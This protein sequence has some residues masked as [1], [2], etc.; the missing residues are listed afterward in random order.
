LSLNESAGKAG[1]IK[2]RVGVSGDGYLGYAVFQRHAR[3]RL[4]LCEPD[5][6]E[7]AI[8]N[9]TIE[10]V[11]NRNNRHNIRQTPVTLNDNQNRAAVAGV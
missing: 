6:L 8:G 1:Q 4:R 11:A 2:R 10:S 3:S 5:S 9:I 7:V